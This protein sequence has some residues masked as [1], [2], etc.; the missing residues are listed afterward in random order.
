[1]PNRVKLSIVTLAL[2]AVTAAFA[3]VKPAYAGAEDNCH[4]K[5]CEVG[6]ES[7]VCC[8]LEAGTINCD[9]CGAVET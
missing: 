9:P 3:P 6:G 4:A 5:P 1:M 2:A 8:L 7:G